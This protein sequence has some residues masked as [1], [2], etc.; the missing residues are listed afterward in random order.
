MLD[1]DTCIYL[2]RQKSERVLKKIKET[3]GD[4]IAI[5]AITLAELEFGVA[6]SGSPEKNAK[7]LAQMLTPINILPF[8]AEAS[9]EYGILRNTLENSGYV[10]G[11]M[12]M[13]IAAHAK[14][15]KLTVVT[16]NVKEFERVEKLRIENWVKDD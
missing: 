2:I 13:L 4:G 11:P 1:T 14:S 10:I 16:N 3:I 15:E 12:D 8:D 6:K 5:S 7:A 9:A